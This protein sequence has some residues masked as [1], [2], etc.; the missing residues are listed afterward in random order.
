[1]LAP[2]VDEL[3]EEERVEVLAE[4]T[5]NGS[6]EVGRERNDV[7][8]NLGVAVPGGPFL[9]AHPRLCSRAPAPLEFGGREGTEGAAAAARAPIVN[10][11]PVTDL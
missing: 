8:V 9:P 2:P 5:P 10:A 4:L 6:L 3:A 7:E 1:M 11:G